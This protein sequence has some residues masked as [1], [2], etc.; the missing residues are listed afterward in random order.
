MR[1]LNA[2]TS[3]IHEFPND[4][5]TPPYAILSH[6]WGEEE[7]TFQHVSKPNVAFRRKGYTKIRFC[8]EQAV[9]DGLEWAWVDTCCIDKTNN[10]ELSEAINS[11]FR[12]YKKAAICYAYLGDVRDASGLSESRWFTR[13]WTLQELIAPK[14]VRFYSADWDLLG[15][16][17]DLQDE[18]QHITGI[19]RS[20]LSTGAFDEICIAK[21]MS[22]AA[23]RQTTRVEDL[24]YSL[25]GI[26]QVNMPLLYGEGKRS[27]IRL[28]E[29]IMKTSDDHTLFAWG[30]PSDLRP[31]DWT[32]IMSC[33]QGSQLHNLLADSPLEFVTRHDIRPLQGLQS[34]MPPIVFSNGVRIELPTWKRGQYRVAAIS[35]YVHDHKT[36]CLCIPLLH[37][38]D[39]YTARC[40]SLVFIAL[41]DWSTWTPETLLVKAP[42]TSIRPSPQVNT[43]SL[44]RVPNRKDC[45]ILDELYCLHGVTYSEATRII[46]VPV[47]KRGAHAVLFFN[48][49]YKPAYRE[50]QDQERTL[51]ISTE[52]PYYP[53][54]RN[55][56]P[57]AIVLGLDTKHWVAFVPILREDKADEDFHELLRNEGE[58]V[59]FC[60][61]KSQLKH[62][63]SNDNDVESLLRKENNHLDKLLYYFIHSG[64]IG[65]QVNVTRFNEPF[66]P[67]RIGRESWEVGL[68]VKLQV[69]NANLTDH[70]VFVC[71]EI[72][73]FKDKHF[74]DEK[75]ELHQEHFTPK[76]WEMKN[77]QWFPRAAPNVNKGL[78]IRIRRIHVERRG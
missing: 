18:L 1:L 17:I 3:E 25:L 5:E 66:Q 9:R 49:I 44:V 53:L 14:D 58:L 36:E 28:Q 15:S 57:F 20:V 13:G 6:T 7:C 31:M 50:Y 19:E 59:Q 29:E 46:T 40:G 73:E 43:F 64:R 24:A 52:K 75:E 2:R 48:P 11:M 71:I 21:R 60:T 32:S 69:S 12:W 47:N 78:H 23:T 51:D 10:A 61:T 76:W 55:S 67:T 62:I 4:D 39:R 42:P 33:S 77:M 72:K 30:I 70:T 16:K 45:F 27:F 65:H 74:L 63:L 35:C 26:F 8:C 41:E 38:S 34:D 37:W 56:F 68:C 54:V 22:W